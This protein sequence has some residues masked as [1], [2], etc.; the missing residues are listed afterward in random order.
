MN[1][2][3]KAVNAILGG[4]TYVAPAPKPK[5][6]NMGEWVNIETPGE[7]IDDEDCL[8]VVLQV[9]CNV[10][11]KRT[12]MRQDKKNG[13][14]VGCWKGGFYERTGHGKGAVIATLPDWSDDVPDTHGEFAGFEL[15][16]KG[17]APKANFNFDSVF[18]DTLADLVGEI[19][20]N[21]SG[22]VHLRVV[23]ST[24]FKEDPSSSDELIR[25]GIAC[26]EDYEQ[27]NGTKALDYLVQVKVY[28]FRVVDKTTAGWAT[29]SR[30]RV[31]GG[32]S[33]L[34]GKRKS[35]VG[36]LVLNGE[37]YGAVVEYVKPGVLIDTSRM[38]ANAPAPAEDSA[39]SC[40]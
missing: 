28:A 3:T 20:G 14:V 38:S 19:P 27:E 26:Y 36:K 30:R 29:Q 37:L 12:R 9:N 4:T 31:V 17:S 13:E 39:D 15:N 24:G 2:F 1:F 25:E 21:Q 10:P 22:Q 40:F 8:T 32:G 33:K 23:L 18:F 34:V 6:A 11:G 7:D 5:L 35:P 16:S